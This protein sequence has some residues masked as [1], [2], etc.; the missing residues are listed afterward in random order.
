[1]SQDR[2]TSYE[3]K[4]RCPYCVE[5]GTDP[6]PHGR[7]NGLDQEGKPLGAWGS[8]D[9]SSNTKGPAA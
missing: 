4:Y 6:C 5:H 7:E 3:L 1:M 8:F 9:R 2:P